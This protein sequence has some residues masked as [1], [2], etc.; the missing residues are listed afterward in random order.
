MLVRLL[1]QVA[2]G[3]DQ[4]TMRPVVGQL[5]SLLL[6][7]L[8]ASAG[9]LVTIDGLI[10]GLWT[11]PPKSARNSIQVAASKLRKQIGPDLIQGT[12]AGYSLRTGLPRIDLSEARMHEAD[13]REAARAGRW[14][15]A[16]AAARQALQLF[17]GVALAGLSAPIVA[18]LRLGAEQLWSAARL[19]HAECLLEVGDPARAA[20]ELGEHIANDPMDESRLHPSHAVTGLARAQRGGPHCL[21]PAAA[22]AVRRTRDESGTRDGNGVHRHLEWRSPG[23]MTARPLPALGRFGA[24]RGPQ[25]A[26]PP[27]RPRPRGGSAPAGSRSGSSTR[28]LG[29]SGRNWQNSACGRG[30]APSD[31]AFL[32]PGGL[33]RPDDSGPIRRCLLPGRAGARPRKRRASSIARRHGSDRARGQRGARTGRRCRTCS[34]AS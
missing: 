24:A 7:Q 23:G 4:N 16:E 2:I 28:D 1:G 31:T 20:E 10:D 9:R 15:A 8:A 22:Q 29:R 3:E 17:A 11:E 12:R 5:P 21:R 33:D 27:D 34:A 32:A 14:I 26:D 13:A 25:R 30:R 18:R 19:L 6:A